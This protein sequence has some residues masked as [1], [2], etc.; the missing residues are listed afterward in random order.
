MTD[1]VS[2]LYDVDM[3]TGV[4]GEGTTN[5]HWYQLGLDKVLTCPWVNTTSTT[6]HPDTNR[7]VT[8]TK[9]PNMD[10]VIAFVE[11][12]HARMMPGVPLAG[13]D[14]AMTNKG[15]L[16]LEANLSC[17]FFRG[18]FDKEAYFN[19]VEAYFLDLAQLDSGA[20]RRAV[21]VR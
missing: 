1:H 2:V 14:V 4:I 13:W 9:V 10:E 20:D 3:K 5:Q 6:V 11:K 15:M 17:N 21:H 7:T 18:S 19:F 8:G 16:L 12:A